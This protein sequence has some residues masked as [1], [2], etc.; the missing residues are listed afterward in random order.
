[1]SRFCDTRF[2]KCCGG[3]TELFENTW[4]P[5]NH[6]YLQRVYD[7][8][9]NPVRSHNIDLTDEEQPVPGSCRTPD[10]FC[11][12]TDRKVLSQ[13]LND[14]DQTTHDFY[15]WKVSYSAV[16]SVVLNQKPHRYGFWRCTGSNTRSARCIRQDY[17]TEDR[18]DQKEP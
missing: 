6:P 12:T 18:W 16:N 15:R 3:I 9:G 7:N 11:N 1:M 5:V 14:Y 2:S 4:E 17:Q 8:S 10:A 13:V